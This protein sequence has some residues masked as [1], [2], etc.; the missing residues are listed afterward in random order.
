MHCPPLV[1]KCFFAF[2]RFLQNVNKLHPFFVRKDE[3]PS[4][5]IFFIPFFL[6]LQATVGR[7][8]ETVGQLT[9]RIIGFCKHTDKLEFAGLLERVIPNQC[10]HWCGNLHRIPGSPS[11]YRPFFC[12]VFRNSSMRSSTSI[13]GIAT[14]VCALARNDRKFGF[15]M[16]M[17]FDARFFLDKF[18]IYRSAYE[19]R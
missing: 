11:S 3:L 8:V 5:Q 12:T 19:S 13:R 18:P 9:I 2:H 6:F 17:L 16:T 10:A 1:V 15:G 4:I 7:R 14:P